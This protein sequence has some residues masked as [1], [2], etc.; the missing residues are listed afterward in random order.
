MGRVGG[1]HP[2]GV[3]RALRGAVGLDKQEPDRARVLRGRRQ[4]KYVALFMLGLPIV[5]Y[6]AYVH[7]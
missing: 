1:T 2:A 6:Y 5:T 4:V 7:R 3:P